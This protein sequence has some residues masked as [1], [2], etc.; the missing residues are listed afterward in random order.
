LSVLRASWHRSPT[1]KTARRKSGRFLFAY[2]LPDKIGTAADNKKAGNKKRRKIVRRFQ[3][4][5]PLME[6]VSP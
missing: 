4:L 1:N 3:I 6:R 2:A 5:C